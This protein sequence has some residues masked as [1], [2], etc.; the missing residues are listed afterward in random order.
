MVKQLEVAIN[1][2]AELSERE[3]EVLAAIIEAELADE[4]RW[5]KRFDETPDTLGRIAERARRQ[6]DAGL[7]SDL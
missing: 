6:Y 7:C 2:A 5:Q 3:Q 1:K 4:E